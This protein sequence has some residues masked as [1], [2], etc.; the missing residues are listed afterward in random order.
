V[1]G[2]SVIPLLAVA[3]LAA[4]HAPVATAQRFKLPAS[5]KDLEQ[6]ARRDSND[7]AAHYNVALAYWN[8]KRWD[9]VERELETAIVI[10][11]SF[12]AAHLA[13]SALPY[14]RD[15]RLF[16]AGAEREVAADVVPVVREAERHYRQAFLLDPFCDTRV[17]GAVLPES[18][19]LVGAR[20]QFAREFFI[21]YL[22]GLGALLEEK[23]DDAYAGFQGAVI[24]IAGDR[25]PDRIPAALHWWRAISAAHTE[26][27]DVAEADL[28]DLINEQRDLEEGDDLLTIPLQT[29][30]FRYVL[31]VVKD[32]GGKPEEARALYRE[33]L[34]QDVG[35]YMANVQLA[36]LHEAAREWDLAIRERQAAVNANPGDASLVFDL[37]VTYGRAGRWADAEQALISAVQENERDTR[38]LYYLGIVETMLNK[39]AEARRAFERFVDLAPSRYAK[40]VDD[41]HR[42]LDALP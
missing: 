22:R 8:A 17:A 18:P 7:A 13:L 26:R 2:P 16:E 21:S 28:A 14:A 19:V 41:A 33:V 15:P 42:R 20:A 34:G 27:W 4:L 32:K 1:R 30:E 29:N 38:A 6:A 39:P 24:A 31:A 35:L 10:E 36:R 3:I 9:A 23:Y 37:G 5:L 40:Q 12:A 25:H 11:P